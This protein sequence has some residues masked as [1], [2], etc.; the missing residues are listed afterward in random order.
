MTDGSQT[1]TVAIKMVRDRNPP[2]AIKRR[3]I[4]DV[5]L[6]S[7]LSHRYLLRLLGYC[8]YESESVG[9]CLYMV[10][11][12]VD[13]GNLVEYFERK[14]DTNRL[15]LLL[16]VAS[17]LTYLH[18]RT[19]GKGAVIHGDVRG[20]NVL[21]TTEGSALLGDFGLSRV[22]QEVAAQTKDYSMTVT[23]AKPNN[24]SRFK[25]PE[26]MFDDLARSTQSDV[27]AFGMLVY[28]VYSGVSPFHEHS[29]AQLPFRL[30]E[31][32]RPERP[33]SCPNDIWEIAVAC[34]AQEPRARPS[35]SAVLKRL[36]DV[37]RATGV[38]IDG[39]VDVAP[40][41]IVHRFIQKIWA[42]IFR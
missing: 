8:T 29:E 9:N 24:A 13:D 40:Q 21:V 12:W 42:L 38:Q 7:G 18:S 14:P 39:I 35:M 17:A 16:Q 36:G 6:W 1:E 34:W 41:S 4:A 32:D 28:Q 23:S 27:W 37:G 22:Y 15:P 10:Y 20:E 33:A 5:R 11:P 3:I 31:G 25:A 19:W 2:P 30:Q 26:V